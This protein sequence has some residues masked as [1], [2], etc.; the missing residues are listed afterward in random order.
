MSEIDGRIFEFT[1][2]PLTDNDY[3]F[4][5]MPTDFKFQAWAI[6]L[7]IISIFLTVILIWLLKKRRDR[8]YIEK[9]TRKVF[10]KHLKISLGITILYLLLIFLRTQNVAFVSMRI[11]IYLL[12][13]ANTGNLIFAFLRSKNFFKK[14]SVKP[15][16][17]EEK[18]GNNY[19]QYLPKKKKK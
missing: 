7:G 12:I 9:F 17:L 4:N 14:E 13:L 15:L 1:F 19:A 5:S 8:F 2:H 16:D 11:W 10:S 3:Y 18:V 6:L